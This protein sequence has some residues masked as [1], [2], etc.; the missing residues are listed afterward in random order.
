ML[1]FAQFNIY[2]GDDGCI[3]DFAAV[4]R[5]SIK[6]YLFTV[7]SR[8]KGCDI[9]THEYPPLRLAYALTIHKAQGMSLPHVVVDAKDVNKAAQLATAIGQAT[10]V[11]GLQLLNFNKDQRPKHIDSVISLYKSCSDNVNVLL[12]SSDYPCY[13]YC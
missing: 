13:Y 11:D 3:V 10:S 7:Y 9:A 12:L 4:G 1:C 2:V 8:E 6:P 5:V